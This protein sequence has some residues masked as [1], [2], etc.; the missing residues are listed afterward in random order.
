MKRTVLLCDAAFSAVPILLALKKRGLRTAVCGSRPNDPGHALADFSLVL[1]YADKELLLRTVAKQRIDFLVP[2]CTDVSYLSCAWVAHELG[3]N[4]FDIPESTRTI[5][6]KDAFREFCRAHGFPTPRSTSLASEVASLRFPVLI[7][8]SDAFS[9]RGIVKVERLED[10][11]RGIDQA[12]S[13][14]NTRTVVFEEFVEGDLYSHSAFLRNGVVMSDFFVNE[15]CTVHPYQVNSSHVCIDLSDR[16]VRALRDWLQ[17]FAARLALVDGLVHTQ[18]ISD[19]DSFHVIEVMRRCPGDLYA[20]LVQKSM[21]VNYPEMYAATFCGFEAEVSK[22]ASIQRYFSRHTVSVD[23]DCIFFSSRL[24]LPAV[25]ASFVPL[26]RTA[27]VLRAAP[28]DRAGIYFIEHQ[29]AGV[30][31]E[32]TPKLM[33]YVSVETGADD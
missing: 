25:Q 11:Q 4:G 8:P 23:H 27:E 26:K 31:R 13:Q 30:M 10:V 16:I 3:L 19:G 22:D 12:K 6:R 29:S 2:G 7:K 24:S 5:H 20:L 15:Y 1:N 33:E 28:M 32:V 21:V 18:F 14:S 17:Q 9:G